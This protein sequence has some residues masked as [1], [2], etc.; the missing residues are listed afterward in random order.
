M[1]NP[2]HV[3]LIPTLNCPARC[4]YCWS[5]EHGSPVMD[6]DIIREVIAWLKDFRED[7]V[8]FT[9]HGGE[10]LLAGPD[11]YRQALPLLSRELSHM[12]PDFAMQTNLWLMTPEMARILAEY[13]VPLGSSID[14]PEELNDRQ[15]GNGYFRK[16]MKGYAIAREEGVRVSFICT[17]TSASVREKEEIVRFFRDQGFVMKLHPA[18]PSLRNANPEPWVLSPEDYRDLLIYLLDHSLEN[19]GSPEIM[20]INDLVKCVF[21]RRGTVCTFA[22][23]VGSTFAIGPDGSIY[24]CYRFVGMPEW[25]MG[26]VHDHPDRESLALSAAGL[27]MSQHKDVVDRDCRDCRHL[28][29][30]RGGCPY[31]AL[32]PTGGEVAGIDPYCIAYRQV[33]DEISDRLNQEIQASCAIE[34]MTVPGQKDKRGK[35]GIMT[36][37]QRMV[38]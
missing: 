31:N 22:D 1:K 21:T 23:C 17:F 15:R 9:F 13:R 14:G 2:F 19:P 10:P 25:V 34:M 26:S 37:M 6:I 4:S 35:S 12:R 36:L 33:F 30:C 32:V 16:T 18:L 8:T 24:P 28:R 29:Y 5:S 3:M 38:R 11:F 27:R 20:N 7:R